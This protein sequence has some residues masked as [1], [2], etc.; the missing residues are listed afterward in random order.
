M[1]IEA[2]R[3]ISLVL[4]RRGKLKAAREIGHAHAVSPADP[5]ITIAG[6]DRNSAHVAPP[7]TEGRRKPLS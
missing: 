5:A 1:F 6:L 3:N 2:F 7:R 4:P